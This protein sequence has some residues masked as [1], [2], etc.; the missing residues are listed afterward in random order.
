MMVGRKVA[1]QVRNQTREKGVAAVAVGS[2]GNQRRKPKKREVKEQGTVAVE[3]EQA[4]EEQET[5]RQ[6]LA[7]VRIRRCPWAVTYLV[8]GTMRRIHRIKQTQKKSTATNNTLTGLPENTLAEVKRV[9]KLRVRV[10]DEMPSEKGPYYKQNVWEYYMVK[11]HWSDGLCSACQHLRMIP[12]C[13]LPCGWPVRLCQTLVRAQPTR[14]KLCCCDC[15]V[16]GGCCISVL[17]MFI[18]LPPILACALLVPAVR[19]Q[20]DTVFNTQGSSTVDTGIYAVI[21]LSVAMTMFL[22][23]RL[24]AGVA[25]KFNISDASDYPGSFLLKVWCCI[26]AFNSRIALHVDRAHGYEKVLRHDTDIVEMS[27][28][29]PKMNPPAQESMA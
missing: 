7:A 2:I 23:S 16:S 25:L 12:C 21:A 15:P 6:A 14:P 18:F 11:A 19:D 28:H 8:T 3:E 22:W 9:A 29:I 10:Q 5:A 1:V 13:V 26:C 24:L 20:V 17:V 27:D 4:K